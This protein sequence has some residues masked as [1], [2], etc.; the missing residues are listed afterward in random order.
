MGRGQVS[1][2]VS[3]VLMSRLFHR[4]KIKSLAQY[5][6]MVKKANKDGP[7]TV[8]MTLFL[9]CENGLDIGTL[10]T[11]PETWPRP[12]FVYTLFSSL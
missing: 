2:L 1:G 11:G 10:E 4:L 9:V 8:L 6:A 5:S 12:I 3:R 7:N